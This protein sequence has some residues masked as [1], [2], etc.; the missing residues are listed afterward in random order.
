VIG[1]L[2]LAGAAVVRFAVLPSASKLPADFATS[3][4][5]EGTFSGLNPAVFA[6]GDGPAVVRDIPVTATRTYKTASVDGDTAVVTRTLERATAGQQQPST[7]VEYAV[8]RGTFESA[9]APSGSSGVVPSEGWIFTLPLH[10]DTNASYTLWDEATAAAYPLRYEDTAAVEGRSTYRFQTTAEGPLADPEA[11][12]L[13]TSL[14]R[15]QLT[16]LAPELADL[17]PAALQAQLPAILAQLPDTIPL[18]WTSS[19]QATIWADTTVGAPIRVQ[20]T[21]QITGGLSLLGQTV[22]I[23]A[24][25]TDLTTTKASEQAIADDASSNASSLNLLGTVLPWSLVGLGVVLLAIALVLALRNRRP[26]AG[27]VTAAEPD[28]RTPAPVR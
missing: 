16:A 1:V 24:G 13:P 17:L 23:P 22:Q 19:T 4:S 25:T 3:Q 7:T 28:A 20:S 5:Y 12:G 14:T 26:P 18:T 6:G 11:L 10:P 2:L 27:A 9:P 8:D 21:Q 15:P